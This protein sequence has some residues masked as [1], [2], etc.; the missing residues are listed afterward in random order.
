MKDMG[1]EDVINI[2]YR[3]APD[4][5]RITLQW[6][7]GNTPTE[8]PAISPSRSADPQER[9]GSHAIRHARV[10]CRIVLTP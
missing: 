9:M 8:R 10:A 3:A 4:P 2:L 7:S 1:W 5:D 6:W